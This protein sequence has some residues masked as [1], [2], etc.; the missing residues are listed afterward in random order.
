MAIHPITAKQLVRLV[1]ERGFFRNEE[2]V[3]RAVGT[4]DAGG[5]LSRESR[6]AAEALAIQ[7]DMLAEH[8]LAER[9]GVNADDHDSVDHFRKMQQL[10]PHA[11]QEDHEGPSS[12]STE[13]YGDQRE[14]YIES[15]HAE[16]GIPQRVLQEQFEQDEAVI[17]G[18]IARILDERI[19]PKE[20]TPTGLVRWN[21]KETIEPGTLEETISD[22]KKLRA[23]KRLLTGRD[24]KLDE[25]IGVFMKDIQ[26]LQQAAHGGSDEPDN[27]TLPPNAVGKPA[28]RQRRHTLE[29][30][31]GD[32]IVNM[33]IDRRD[34][35]MRVSKSL[36]GNRL[37]STLR[38]V[39]EDLA[40]SMI[41]EVQEAIR[42]SKAV[43]RKTKL[44]TVEE[45][46][47]DVPEFGLRDD[48][49]PIPMLRDFRH[50]M[51]REFTNYVGMLE[52][53]GAHEDAAE[54]QFRHDYKRLRKVI[55]DVIADRYHDTEKTRFA[56]TINMVDG[57][58]DHVAELRT[59]GQLSPHAIRA[60][61]TLLE[62][63]PAIK[64]AVAKIEHLQNRGGGKQ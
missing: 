54:R 8:I 10:Y 11:K 61:D 63:L 12:G 13:R 18:V 20:V 33:A 53:A 32:E 3:A 60:A 26:H 40:C 21:D 14:N 62:Q 34:H 19:T 31:D 23:S 28:M 56:V 39:R 36:R 45:T 7:R 42:T 9:I 22:L 51:G 43:T 44:A 49:S 47:P 48:D 4:L 15:L 25:A 57:L 50:K 46:L 5:A 24:A 58:I 16:L 1:E 37:E 55:R 27:S 41:T 35:P 64:P 6:E 17:R 52:A 30:L 38:T 59:S 2:E 29:T